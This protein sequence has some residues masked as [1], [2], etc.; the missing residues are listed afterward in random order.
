MRSYSYPKQVGLGIAGLLAVL[1]QSTSTAETPIQRTQDWRVYH[2]DAAGSHYSKLDQ[3]NTSNVHKLKIAWIYNTGDKRD[4]NRSQIQC[5]PLIV[6][7]VLFGT[8]P[9][10]KVL[11]LDAATGK[12]RWSFDPYASG[13]QQD[14]SGINRGLAYW[15]DGDDRRILVG[16]GGNLYALNA[17]TG[18]LISSFGRQGVVDLHEGLGR[19]VKD[20]YVLATT[21][22][23]IYKDLLILGSRVSEGPGPAAPGHIR[24]Y[25]VRSGKIRWIFHTIPYPGEFGQDTW[26]SDAWKRIGGVNAWS[27]ITVDETRGLVFLPTGSPAFDFWGGNRPG[28]NL[29]GN[30]VLALN[31]S[32]GERVWHYQVVHHDLWDRDLP[33]APN[34]VTVEREGRRVD[35][36]AQVTKSGLIFLLD[37]ETG[38][39]LFPV[40]ER[41]V[42]ASDLRGEAPWPTQPFPLIQ[43]SFA[44]QI[45]TESDVTDIS[46][47]AHS[48]VLDRLR[49]TRTGEPFIP[50]STSGTIIFP[51]FDGGAE[52]GGAAFES[53]T[54]LLYVNANEMP[55][56][57][58]MVEL[59][60]ENGR[61]SFPLGQRIYSQ[62]CATCHGLDREGD[63]EHVFP[64][65]VGVEKKMSQQKVKQLIEAGKGV[66]PSFRFLSTTERDALVNF[67]FGI[68]QPAD[69]PQSKPPADDEKAEPDIPYTHTGYN[70]FLDAEGYPAVKPPWGTLNA[71]NLNRGTLEWSVPLGEFPELTRRGIPPTGTENY[72]GPVVTAGGLVFIGASKDGKFRAFDKKTGRLL[73]E[74]QLPFGGYA[75]PATYL[76]GGKQYVVI[77]AGGGKMGTPSGD[78]YVAFAL[79]DE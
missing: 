44:R 68:P 2:G 78:A 56:I 20:L 24:A 72:G 69:N 46:P 25:D 77:A 6:D 38:K 19:D 33:A 18:Q 52:W 41:P 75:T 5:N 1:L 73:W 66:M 59:A 34:L 31:A 43:P 15:E 27:G 7:G 26:P 4:D 47:Q 22:G 62:H 53:E 13:R 45:F 30:C 65:L 11:A 42:P 74:T 37:R 50:P 57:L 10:L 71:I 48:Q 36:V 58:T 63:P 29:F 76:V 16:V 55:W 23:A 3:I 61:A 9:R 54:G 64:S 79:A 35:A 39:P 49:K 28:A 51:G 8:S 32:T 67:L 70:R 21:P 40:E 14:P 12:R 60:P 17:L